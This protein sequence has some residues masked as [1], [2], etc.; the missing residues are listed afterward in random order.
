MHAH[1]DPV[2]V[3]EDCVDRNVQADRVDLSCTRQNPDLALLRRASDN[4][5]SA[6]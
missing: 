1:N 6:L 5:P 2:T 4:P 3:T